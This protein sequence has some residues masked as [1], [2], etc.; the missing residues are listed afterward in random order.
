MSEYHRLV[1]FQ[2]YIKLG[3]YQKALVDCDWALKV[4][5]SFL[6]HMTILSLSPE[7][8]RKQ[9]HACPLKGLSFLIC[10]MEWNRVAGRVGTC[11]Q[12]T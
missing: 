12:C 1:S 11:I 2:A 8:H 7:V 3:D 9:L 5:D 6:G 10:E 4:R